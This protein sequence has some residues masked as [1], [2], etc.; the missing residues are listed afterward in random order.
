M[1]DLVRRGLTN[2]EISTELV[3]RGYEPASSA[4][5]SAWR[6]RHGHPVRKSTPHRLNLI[7]WKVSVQHSR[8]RYYVCLALEARDRSGGELALKDRFRRDKFVAELA[9]LRMVVD[10]DRDTG[11]TLRPAR[12]GIDRDLIRDPRLA[13][14]GSIKEFDPAQ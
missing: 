7:P 14:D 3:R 8:H 9:T 2:K 12:K 5:V 10:Y 6:K 4:A 11:W 1:E 13:D